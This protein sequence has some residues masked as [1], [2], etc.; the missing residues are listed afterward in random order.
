MHGSSG[1]MKLQK[2]KAKRNKQ[3]LMLPTA[4]LKALHAVCS[5]KLSG[6]CGEF[7]HPKKRNL[8]F[9]GL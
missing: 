9:K 3:K 1:S 4:C 6:Y 2:R 7:C 8:K 5:R